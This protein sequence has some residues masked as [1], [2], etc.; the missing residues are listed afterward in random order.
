MSIEEDLVGS[1][2]ELT[3]EEK[4]QLAQEEG[5]EGQ[6][7]DQIEEVDQATL[8]AL[9]NGTGEG[10]ENNDP[11]KNQ[12][13]PTDQNQEN[14]A[15]VD[16]ANQ[17]QE[18]E[19]TIVREQ[20]D[21]FETS[22]ND[23]QIKIDEYDQKE[24]STLTEIDELGKLLDE[25]EIGQGEYTSRLKRL[26][27]QL[28]SLKNASQ[29][30]HQQYQHTD[31]EYKD[32]AQDQQ[33]KHSHQWQS[34]LTHFLEENPAYI[35]DG[36]YKTRFDEV[37]Y[38]LRD[39]EVFTGLSFA[40]VIATVQHRV[41]IELGQPEKPKKAAAKALPKRD[42]VTI[43]PSMNQLQQLEDNSGGDEFAMIDRLQGIEYEQAIEKLEKNNPEAYKRYMS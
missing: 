10:G 28:E 29:T 24:Q 39:K 1:E 5:E 35:E 42:H 32:F 20:V 17:A 7:D 21:L 26:E 2:F 9:L 40:Q 3:E 15:V 16:T 12:D 37:F 18:Q 11:E 4:A 6:D 25:G 33:D 13:T 8:D 14:N 34:E 38:D 43:P 31:Q 27:L 22:L 41:E 23:L 30:A 19:Q 36:A